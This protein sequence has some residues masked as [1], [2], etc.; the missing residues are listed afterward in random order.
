MIKPNRTFTYECP[1]ISYFTNKRTLV[2]TGVYPDGNCFFHAMLRAIDTNYR[3]QTNHVAHSRLV[4][5]FRKEIS[6][7]VTFDF[8]QS[9]G[10]GE[11]FR[12]QFQQEFNDVLREYYGNTNFISELYLQSEE[13]DVSASANN[14]SQEEPIEYNK[15]ILQVIFKLISIETIDKDIIPN[16][17]KSDNFYVSF[18]S[19]T[20]SYLGKKLYSI[21]NKQQLSNI[22]NEMCDY[23]IDLFRITHNRI[24]QH[25][26]RDL[27]CMGNF[28]DSFQLE[29]ISRFVK[30]NFL[31][32]NEKTQKPYDGFSHI[33][34][35]DPEKPCLLFL[36]V[37]EN[38]FE[39]LGELENNNIINRIFS[40]DDPIIIGVKSLSE[41]G[42][43]EI[44]EHTQTILES[45]NTKR[46][47]SRSRSR[48]KNKVFV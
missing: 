9:L 6:E 31:F 34:S 35:F 39:I 18:C 5:K 2:R 12:I 25:F 15:D 44:L 42:N 1:N 33:V 11:N 28:V 4:E 17:L 41:N 37:G 13:T 19:E 46:S 23:F 8:Y 40:S 16:V 48:G 3:K 22:C 7:W 32:I 36:W 47:R 26:K 27:R 29:C 30:Y 24:F 43:V 38:H 20:S 21:V 14:N 45:I 10:K